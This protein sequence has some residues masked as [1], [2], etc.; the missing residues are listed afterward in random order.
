MR[1]DRFDQILQGNLLTFWRSMKQSSDQHQQARIRKAQTEFSSLSDQ[2]AAQLAFAR[3]DME[4]SITNMSEE[5]LCAKLTCHQLTDDNALGINISSQFTETDIGNLIRYI[6][7][8]DRVSQLLSHVEENIRRLP[9]VLE[10]IA[11]G[12]EINDLESLEEISQ[13][14]DEFHHSFSSAAEAGIHGVEYHVNEDD[15]DLTFF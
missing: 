6:Q 15:D 9:D 14:K 5:L 1:I 2:W 12:L 13:L 11:N 8:Q 10:N 4:A 7:F 3:A